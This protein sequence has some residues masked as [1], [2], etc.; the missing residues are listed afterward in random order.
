M[1]KNKPRWKNLPVYEMM[2][3]KAKQSGVSEETCEFLRSKRRS[4]KKMIYTAP[5]GKEVAFDAWEDDTE[6]YGTYWADICPECC[7]K[8]KKELWGKLSD[9]A[10][11]E[12]SCYIC[13]CENTNAEA[14]VDF[15]KNE[16]RFEQ[17]EDYG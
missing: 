11:G 6:E 5:N 2:I 4:P 12:A 14:Y 15:D 8:Y 3:R 1:K 7:K 9:G 16:V 13:G 17:E 10:S